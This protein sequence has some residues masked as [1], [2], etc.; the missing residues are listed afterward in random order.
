VGALDDEG[1]LWIMGRLPHV[2]TTAAGPVTPV[3]LEQRIEARPEVRAAA[4][5]GVGPA[6]A[7]QVVAVVVPTGRPRRGAVAPL[8]LVEAVRA[9]AGSPLAAVLRIKA[10]PVDIRH[11]SKVDRRAVARWA[12]A[13]LAGRG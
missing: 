1:R 4:V 5:V 8:D 12:E 7:Q 9:A 3:G 2:I 10:L 6:G 11:Q 13:A